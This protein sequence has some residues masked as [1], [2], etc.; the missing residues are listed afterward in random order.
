MEEIKISVIIPAYNVEKYINR[1]LESIISQTLKDIEII[2]VNDGSTDSTLKKIALFMEKDER[3]KLINK[4]NEGLSCARNDGIKNAKGDYIFHVDGDDFIKNT[5]L[6]ELYSYAIRKDLDVV[7]SDVYVYKNKNDVKIMKDIEIKNKE[8]ISA[9]EYLAKFFNNEGTYTV[10]NKLWKKDLYIDNNVFHPKNISYG[11]DGCTVPRLIINA[12]KIGKINKCFY[13]YCMNEESMTKKGERRK[14]YEYMKGY[15]LVKDYFQDKN[16][17]WYKDYDFNYKFYSVYVHVL[18]KSY[19]N[20]VIQKNENKDFK[21]I[22]DEMLDFI[23]KND[24]SLNNE[25]ASQRDKDNI[26][27]LKFY[28]KSILLG[29]IVRVILKRKRKL[30]NSIKKRIK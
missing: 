18:D 1:C 26:I 5:T 2:V 29:E 24:F 25:Y 28:R 11:E 27:M 16:I 13:Y 7:T 21:M 6:E 10:C 4:N 3:I 8:I 17:S 23:R 12:N 15:L 22:Y 20:K 14:V 19:Y 30:I 9:K